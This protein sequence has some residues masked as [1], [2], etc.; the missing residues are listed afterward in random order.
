MRR[1][2]QTPTDR[3][4]LT[5]DGLGVAH[6]AEAFWSYAIIMAATSDDFCE[7]G[8]GF[9]VSRERVG[10]NLARYRLLDGRAQFLKRWFK[11][12]HRG[13]RSSDWLVKQF[14]GNAAEVS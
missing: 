14:D 8:N 10:A 3:T 2:G 6:G 4:R 5:V 7:L 13:R 9:S 12:H 1:E 11:A